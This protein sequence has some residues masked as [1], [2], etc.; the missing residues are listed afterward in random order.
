MDILDVEKLP[1]DHFN[2]FKNIT[3]YSYVDIVDLFEFFKDKII[4]DCK[5]D[6]SGKSKEKRKKVSKLKYMRNQDAIAFC[7]IDE[8]LKNKNKLLKNS[9]R[10]LID[11]KFEERNF[12]IPQGSPIS[13]ILANIYLLKFDRKINQFLN[14]VNGIYRRYSDDIVVICPKEKKD[15]ITE[16]ILE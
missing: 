9:K 12:G 15:I 8:F 13:S 5:N 6:E 1:S 14:T 11:G 4:C 3:R 16:L 7:T 2:V 10:I